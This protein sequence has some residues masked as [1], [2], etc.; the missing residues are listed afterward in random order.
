[1]TSDDIDRKALATKTLGV[2]GAVASIA[3]AAGVVYRVLDSNDAITALREES[4]LLLLILL[5]TIG[6][7]RNFQIAISLRKKQ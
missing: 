3:L 4:F 6:T 1:M 5:A 2:I 7:V